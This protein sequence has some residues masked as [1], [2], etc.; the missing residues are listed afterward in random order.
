[1]ISLFSNRNTKPTKIRECP[2]RFEELGGVDSIQVMIPTKERKEMHSLDPSK[3]MKIG[4]QEMKEG[5]QMLIHTGPHRL[6]S[7]P[8]TSTNTEYNTIKVDTCSEKIAYSR[9]NTLYSPPK[10]QILASHHPSFEKDPEVGWCG[11]L[12]RYV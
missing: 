12:T 8:I 9:Q 11:H 6:T 5:T 7:P 3:E 10:Q 4:T 1:M 2:R